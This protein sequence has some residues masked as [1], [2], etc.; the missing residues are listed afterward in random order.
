MIP[1]SGCARCLMAAAVLAA[2]CLAGSAGADEAAKPAYWQDWHVLGPFPNED[3]KGFAA[4]HPPEKQVDLEGSFTGLGGASI[5]WQHIGSPGATGD[6]PVDLRGAL[7]AKAGACGYAYTTI[8]SERERRVNLL[9][10]ADGSVALWVNGKQVLSKE[11]PRAA[12]TDEFAAEVTFQKGPNAVLLKSC[13]TGEPWTFCLR[14]AAPPAEQARRYTLEND[15]VRLVFDYLGRPVEIFNKEA[16]VAC[17]VPAGQAEP[18]PAFIV[19]A[20]SRNQAVYLRDPL[21]KEG[22]GF[23]SADPRLLMA[24]TSSGDLLRL[25]VEPWRT[26]EAAVTEAGGARTLTCKYRLAGGIEMTTA[27]TLPAKGGASEWQASAANVADVKPRQQLRVYRVLFPILGGLCVG[28]R[29][30]ENFLAR[31][32]VQGELIPNPSQ[33]KFHRPGSPDARTNVLTYPGWASMPWMDLYRAGAPS[34]AGPAGAAGLYFASYDPTYQQV[35]IEA[36]PDAGRKTLAMGMRTLAFLEPGQ[37]WQSQKF[38]VAAHSG[39]W[40]WAADRYREDSARWFKKRDVPEWVA[41]SDGW[42]GTGSANYRYSDLPAML[43][44]ARWLGLDYLQCWSEMIEKVGPG[45]SRK[46][47]YCFFLPDPERGG[48]KEMAE[49]VKKVRAMGG[50]IGF[51]SNFWTWDADTANCL[52]QW[53]DRIP[54]DVKIPD[55]TEFR[56]YMSVFPDGRMEAGDY[57]DGYAGACPGAPG[58]RDYLQFWI[59]DKY[60]KQYG[61]DAWYI[62]SFPVTMFGAARVCFSPHHAGGRPHG[63]GPGLVE[64]V[65]TLRDASA[66]SVKLAI[67]SESVN[68]VF[69]QYNSHALGLELIDGLTEYQKPEI[70]TYAFPHHPIFSGSCNGAGSGL[71]YYYK[72]IKEPTRPE[73]FNRVFMMGYR[74]DILGYPLRKD[75]PNMV[76]LRGL[77]ALRQ[78]IK[79]HLYRSSFK[80]ETGLGTLPADVYAKVFRHD[81]AKSVIVVLVDR[82]EKKDAMA[83][84]IDPAALGVGAPKKAAFFT[85]GGGEA[86]ALPVRAAGEGRAAVDV[87]ARPSAPAAII[88]TP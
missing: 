35:D 4:V 12:R 70:Y 87:P 73:T 55:W 74:F 72:D 63:V 27:V 50:H 54:A 15:A 69:M 13:Q 71:K 23:C 60:V 81:E 11:G 18:A 68:D 52:R 46:W 59:V 65:R 76:Y 36:V 21:L 33:Y 30:E 1:D 14:L 80:D 2:A 77:I 40:H 10:G 39:D 31:T 85:L 86:V 84:S 49:G 32:F 43:E 34:A 44:E 64:F 82:R 24:T 79:G 25:T 53:K 38:I 6:R 88:F 51:Y 45:K 29:P 57:Y 3:N 67:T 7:H 37:K 47:Y 58:W 83:V 48:E 8:H 56:N 19:D 5:R 78:K 28:D 66:S 61:V 9:L 20:Y 22:G 62:D 16:G 17:M 41:D 75:D 42:F 26:P